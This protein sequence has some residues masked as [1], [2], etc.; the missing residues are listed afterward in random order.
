MFHLFSAH[1]GGITSI[2]SLFFSNPDNFWWFSQKSFSIPPI[3][4]QIVSKCIFLVPLH[5]CLVIPTLCGVITLYLIVVLFKSWQS[6]YFSSEKFSDTPN[7]FPY[8]S[9]SFY[10]LEQPLLLLCNRTDNKILTSSQSLSIKIRIK[11]SEKNMVEY[12][13][14]PVCWSWAGKWQVTNA[15]YRQMPEKLEGV[16]FWRLYST[17][18][19]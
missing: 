4:S 8:I 14:W 15:E 3:I 12:V 11:V 10:R 6:F 19:R 1:C 5:C 17:I 18:L 16:C 13:T 7:K 9:F 2:K